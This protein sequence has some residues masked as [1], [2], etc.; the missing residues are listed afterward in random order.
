[1]TDH[2]VGGIGL[3]LVW[4]WWLVIIA[5]PAQAHIWRAAA[6]LGSSSLALA[7]GV[8]LLAGVPALVAAILASGSASIAHIAFKGAL[9]KRYGSHV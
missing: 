2:V 4:G 7:V 5:S 8:Y 1:M 3:G 9:R 6:V